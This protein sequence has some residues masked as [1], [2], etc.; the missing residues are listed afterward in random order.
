MT[1]RRVVRCRVC[2]LNQFEPAN[3]KCRKC[4]YNL[5]PPIPKLPEPPMELV[6]EPEAPFQRSYNVSD[7]SKRIRIYRTEL[8]KTQAMVSGKDTHAY[9]SRIENGHMPSIA[10]LEYIAS[11][12]DIPIAWLLEPIS[13]DRMADLFLR[14]IMVEVRKIGGLREQQWQFI[15]KAVKQL[16]GGANAVV[17]AECGGVRR[18][19]DDSRVENRTWA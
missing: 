7:V 8:G 17:Q 19:V 1:D 6:D 10:Y 11:Q 4:H 13:K 18:Q 9:L 14:R 3:K 12:L 15:T 5:A 2:K 16:R